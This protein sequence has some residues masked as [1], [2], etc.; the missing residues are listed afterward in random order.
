MKRI[1]AII[2]FLL[3]ALAGSPA[4]LALE[5]EVLSP[6]QEGYLDIHNISTGKGDATFIV[7]PDGTKMLIDAG[8]MTGSRFICPA[9]PSDSLAPGEW[10]A[11]YIKHF[12]AAAPGPA[13]KVDYFSL[14]HFHE[15]H[16]GCAQALKPGPHYGICGIMEVAQ[17]IRFGKIVDREYP[18]YTVRDGVKGDAA[19]REYIKFV[20]YQ[21]DSCGVAAEK[22]VIGSRRQFAMVHDPSA[23]RGAFEI[24]GIA[25]SGYIS[26]GRGLGKRPFVE[27]DTLTL[28]ENMY[29]TAILLRYGDFTYYNGGDLG[30]GIYG[31]YSSHR[32]F[33]SQIADLI[34][35]V[36][37]MKADHHAWKE[38]MNPY[39]LWKTRPRAILVQCSHVN[40]PWKDTVRRMLDPLL[41]VVPEI[42]VT[43][44]SGRSQI[45]EELFS[46]L[47]PAGHIVVRVYPG[48][49][50]WQI[51]VLDNT[52]E[53]FRIKYE[54]ELNE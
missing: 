20:R 37:V 26:T 49:G 28:D 22:F 1:L 42:Y 9:F 6:W 21:A 17:S 36:T 43:T 4:A 48:G 53:E 2:L 25:G 54:S 44:E 14:T 40:H 19:K 34:G 15:D 47:K 11:R 41:P 3:G 16:F 33:E 32:D 27:N 51:F 24:R 35:P 18:D 52:S 8:D 31:A 46:A 5:P 39:F 50:C 45:G 30:G 29:S 12:G 10:I 38:V 23:Y 13:D 7:M